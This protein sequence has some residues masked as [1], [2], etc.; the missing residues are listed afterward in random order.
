M[1]PEPVR[2]T[3]DRDPAPMEEIDGP[4]DEPAGPVEK[5]TGPVTEGTGPVEEPGKRPPEET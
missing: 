3:V 2:E 4:V 5:L 1:I